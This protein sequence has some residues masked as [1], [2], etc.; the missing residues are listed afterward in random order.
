MSYYKLKIIEQLCCVPTLQKRRGFIYWSTPEGRLNDKILSKRC[1][2]N[3]VNSP[4][5]SAPPSFYLWGYKVPILV[6]SI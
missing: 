5:V 1:L 6:P 2:F 3:S 4:S